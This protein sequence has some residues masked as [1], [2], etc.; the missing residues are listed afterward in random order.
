MN[1]EPELTPSQTIG[2]FFHDALLDRIYS[3]LVSLDH[4]EAIVIRERSMT[5]QARSCLTL[6]SRSGRPTGRALRSSCRRQG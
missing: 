6:W 4:P 3:E 2:P 5:G 1:P